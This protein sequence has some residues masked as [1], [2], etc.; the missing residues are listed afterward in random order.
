[1]GLVHGK[2]YTRCVFGKFKEMGKH[3]IVE[4][5]LVQAFFKT[6]AQAKLGNECL[7]I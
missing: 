3:P 1:M 4:S 2:E 6:I 7:D 5:F